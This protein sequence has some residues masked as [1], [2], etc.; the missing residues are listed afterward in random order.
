MQRAIA[1]AI[2]VGSALQNKSVTSG[3]AIA[4]AR[5]RHNALTLRAA[6]DVVVGF[7]NS[8]T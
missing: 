1:T 5:A 6:I 4:N 8:R 3:A 7:F 2:N